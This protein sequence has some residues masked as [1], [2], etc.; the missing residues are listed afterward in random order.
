MLTLSDNL[1]HLLQLTL[2]LAAGVVLIIYAPSIPPIAILTMLSTPVGVLLGVK[3]TQSAANAASATSA[4]I[5]QNTEAT[6]ANTA[7]TMAAAQQSLPTT[8]PTPSNAAG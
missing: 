2:I 4:A 1:T 3:V 7:A 8:P 6:K 5:S